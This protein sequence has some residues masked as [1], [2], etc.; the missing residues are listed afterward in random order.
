MKSKKR[1]V[2]L[3][4]LLFAIVMG[5]ESYRDRALPEQ[6]LQEA[7]AAWDQHRASFGNTPDYWVI[8]DLSR[9]LYER[10]LWLYDPES[11][12]V[13]MNVHTS[14]AWNSGFLRATRFSNTSGSSTSCYGSFRTG[15]AYVSSFQ[16]E[17]S[18]AG[19]RIHGLDEGVNDAA[20][21]RNIVFHPHY[22]P[23]SEGCYMTRP[24]VNEVLVNKIKGG[25]FVY[26]SPGRISD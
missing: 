1:I 20:Y 4:L 14:H 25:S 18:K 3:A 7:K 8:I 26:V 11:K 24:A 6:L 15:E 21:G 10:R 16:F 17:E 13:L 22:W 12:K 2:L 23:W 5:F 19:L 9:P